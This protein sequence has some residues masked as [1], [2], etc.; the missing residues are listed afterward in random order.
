MTKQTKDILIGVLM[1]LPAVAILLAVLILG[2]GLKTTMIGIAVF[3]ASCL[4]TIMLI[5]GII[6]LFTNL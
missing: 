5:G 3:I 2:F 1:L 4:A 6:R